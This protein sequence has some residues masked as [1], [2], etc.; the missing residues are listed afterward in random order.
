M[1]RPWLIV[2]ADFVKTGGQDRAN[3]ALASYLARQGHE[4]HLVAHRADDEL[5]A[6]PNVTFHRSAKPLRSTLLGEPFLNRVGKRIARGLGN[7]RV[8]VNGGNCDWP[9]VN[10]VHYVHAAYDREA[11]VGAGPIRRARMRVAQKR[12]VAGERRA[13]GNA[14][15]VVANSHRTQCDLVDRL[16]VPPERLRVIYYGID[17]AAFRPAEPGEREQTRRRLGWPNDRTII[18]FV[19]ALGDRRKGFDTVLAAWQI[20]LRQHPEFNTL[21]CVIGQGAELPMWKKR[22][23]DAG[24]TDRIVFL[25]FRD[26]VPELM[27]AADGLVSPTR[28]E[29]YGLAV[30]EAICCGIP[31]IVSAD[32]GVAE[33]YPPALHAFLLPDP[34]D[35]ADVAMRIR[36][37]CCNEAK[38][39]VKEFSESLRARNWDSMAAEIVAAAEADPS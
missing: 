36:S 13:L 35:A 25:G 11:G 28:Y 5:T 26:D 7:A 23:D 22:I 6:M 24:M 31:A 29:A 39:D 1:N 12:F 17:A 9:D 30:H 19:G 10:W 2:S 16:G 4:V 3:F 21:L 34:D 8:V 27:R 15:V 38:S 32:A 14:R 20:L 18:L 37:L 33:R